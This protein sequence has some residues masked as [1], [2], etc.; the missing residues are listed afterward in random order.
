MQAR[1]LT[2]VEIGV[3]GLPSASPVAPRF[4]TWFPVPFRAPDVPPANGVNPTPVADGVVLE[5]DAVDLE[6][7][8]YVISRS[9]SQDGPWTEIHRTTETRYVYSD[10]SGKT[11]WFQITPTVRG[12]TGTGTVVGAVP[13]TTSKDLAEQQTKLAAEISARIQAIADEAAARAAG[14]AQAAQ[15]L[16]AEALLRQQGVT[17]AMQAISAEAQVRIDALLNEKMAREAAISREEQLRQSADESLARAVSEVAAGS[18]TQFDSIKLWPFNQTIE[19]WTG[20]GAPTLVDGWLRPANHAT[21]PWVQSPVELAVDGSAYRFVKLR[22]KRVGSPTWKGLLQWITTVDQDWNAAKS[23]SAREPVWDGDGVATIDVQDVAWWPATIDAIRLQVGDAQAVADYYL[24]DYVAVGRPQPGASVAL[25]QEETLARIAADSAEALQRSSLAVQMRGDYEG[26][27]VTGVRSGLVASERDARINGDGVN[28]QAIQLINARMP[29]GNGKTASEASVQQLAQANAAEHAAMGQQIDQI[30][31]S[32]GEKADSTVVAQLRSEVNTIDG[33][34]RA[35]SQSLTSLT[36]RVSFAEGGVSANSSAI[37][38]LASTVSQQGETV[39]AH[40]EQLTQIGGKVTDLEG[41][42][43]ANSSAISG[44]TTR[45]TQQS[46]RLDSQAEQL[47]QL[48]SRVGDVDGKTNAN[49][50]TIGGLTTRVTQTEQGLAAQVTQ[51]GRL[52][53]RLESSNPN[54]LQNPKWSNGWTNWSVTEGGSIGYSDWDGTFAFLAPRPG[55][56]RYMFQAVNFGGIPYTPFTGSV[57][58]YRNS[59]RG[60]VFAQMEFFDAA[61]NRIGT[62]PR[63]DATHAP[64]SWK[65]YEFTGET[66]PGCA[67]VQIA[68]YI[69]DTDYNSSFRRAK[70]ETGRYATPFDEGRNVDGLASG[71]SNLNAAVTRHEGQITANANA[72]QGVQAQLGGKA[73]AAVVVTMDATMKSLGASGNLL[74]NSTFPMWNRSGWSWWGNAGDW[75]KELGNPT[76]LN[77]WNQPGI[78]GI[79]SVAKG[80]TAVGE[81]RV[82]GNDQDIAIE[83]GKTYCISAYMQLHR[84]D[85]QIALFYYDAAGNPLP[86]AAGTWI[87]QNGGNSAASGLTSLPRPFVIVKAPPGCRRARMAVYIR[88][89]AGADTSAPYFWMFRPM[90]SQ[91]LDGATTAPAWTAGG[92]EASAQWGV[93]V[94]ADKK[95]GGVQLSATGEISAFDVLADMFRVSSPSAGM[96]T[97][98][99][100][101]HWRVY[102]QN[103]RLRMRWGVVP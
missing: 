37:S 22:L 4:S 89:A 41:K 27:D 102:D 67:K 81:I 12:K 13:P 88:A 54:L 15:D 48:S 91:V 19:G 62:T 64:G 78:T 44:L 96:R 25:V 50:S 46:G 10:G 7:V 60:A 87:P 73:D 20:N 101:G 43:L 11:W 26:S 103:G 16:V 77:D 68:L 82:F 40:T 36:D 85:A 24:I 65:R 92:Q 61:N 59:T 35:N 17:E 58:M 94:R 100:D 86:G 90:F 74:P 14:L 52:E 28:A 18:G 9:E 42:E 31:V 72:V 2:L 71:F 79:G 3:G 57:D 8:I 66:P 38:G 33:Q 97:E 1:K 6:G 30:G 32:L 63:A 39:S 51:T 49:A 84:C 53:A 23:A 69:Y 70:L 5:W 29:D 93:N 95:I 21:A 56:Y 55:D 47:T 75:F 76:G 83:P 45:V 80:N 34:V 99:S 98:F